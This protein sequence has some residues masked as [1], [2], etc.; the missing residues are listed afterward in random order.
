[1]SHAGHLTTEHLKVVRSELWDVRHK[2]RKIG[3][4][5]DLWLAELECIQA[6]HKDDFGACLEDMIIVLLKQTELKVTWGIIVAALK[7]PT[8][9]EEGVAFDIADK[10]LR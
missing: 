2:W 5:L 6:K 3:V 10:Y 1:M 9:G 7:E 8:V 4:E